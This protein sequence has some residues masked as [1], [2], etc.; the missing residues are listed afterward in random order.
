MQSKVIIMGRN[1][2]SLL[3]MIHAIDSKEY[4]IFVIHT[5]RKFKKLSIYPERYSKHIKK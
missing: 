4:D 1:Y 5:V 2:T 3:G